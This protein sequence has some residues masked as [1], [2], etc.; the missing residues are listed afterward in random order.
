MSWKALSVETMVS[1]DHKTSSRYEDVMCTAHGAGVVA[2][3]K[4]QRS[5][6]STEGSVLGSTHKAVLCCM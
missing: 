1:I 6:Q 4:E 2:A 5:L 3:Q